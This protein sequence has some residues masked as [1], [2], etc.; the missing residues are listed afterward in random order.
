MRFCDD[1]RALG[2]CGA[3]C[4]LSGCSPLFAALADLFSW[5]ARGF[6]RRRVVREKKPRREREHG[7]ANMRVF[8]VAA[9]SFLSAVLAFSRCCLSMGCLFAGHHKVLLGC[10]KGREELES[11]HVCAAAP[12]LDD[13]RAAPA[14]A[15]LCSPSPLSNHQQ[16]ASPRCLCRRLA[17]FPPIIEFQLQLFTAC[18]I[19]SCPPC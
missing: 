9:V 3:G 13:S 4:A 14:F 5:W 1:V 12:H 10:S 17:N 7:T 15:W 16:S 11:G 19:A 6:A 2:R 8:A 18:R